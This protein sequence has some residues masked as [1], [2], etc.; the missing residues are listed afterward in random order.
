MNEMRKLIEAIK[1]INEDEYTDME[2]LQDDV[3]EFINNPGN[4]ALYNEE[5]QVKFWKEILNKLDRLSGY[6]L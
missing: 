5:D 1:T 2:P 3:V 6:D 4:F